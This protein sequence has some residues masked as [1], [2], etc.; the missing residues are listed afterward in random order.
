MTNYQ[1][2]DRIFPFGFSRGAFTARAVSGLIDLC[3][4][5]RSGTDNLIPPRCRSPGWTRRG[6]KQRRNS[7]SR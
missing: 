2:E 7:F 6:G 5:L 4:L 1:P 3:G